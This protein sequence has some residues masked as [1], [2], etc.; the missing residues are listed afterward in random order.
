MST[1]NFARFPAGRVQKEVAMLNA[2]SMPL[3]ALPG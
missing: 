2:L 3:P 1:L